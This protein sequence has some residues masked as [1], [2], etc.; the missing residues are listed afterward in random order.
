MAFLEQRLDPRITDGARSTVMWKRRKSYTASGKLDQDFR[1]SHF[2][3]EL[4]IAYTA[5]PVEQYHALEDVFHVVMGNAHAGFRAKNWSDF[6]ATA[7]NSGLSLISGS[8]WQL[9]RKHA[10]LGEQYLKPIKKPVE[11]TVAVF[12]A[13][14]AALS[15]V[16]DYTLG[17]FTGGG[18]PDYWTG[19]FDIPV[20]F[21]NDEWVGNFMG[22]SEEMFL[23]PGKILLEELRRP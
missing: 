23:Y 18:T 8:T 5:R 20:T 16:I 7:T 15:G 4:D 17:T 10:A 13:G 14:G 9:C 2:K 11:A 1:W 22:T 3:Y 6:A 19:E 12:A 21:V